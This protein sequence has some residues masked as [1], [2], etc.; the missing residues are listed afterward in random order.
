M[1]G[2]IGGL[3]GPGSGF[4]GRFCRGGDVGG[5]GGIIGGEFGG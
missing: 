4:V 5:Y 1:G 2:G 3:G